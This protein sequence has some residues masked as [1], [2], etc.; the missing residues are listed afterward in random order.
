MPFEIERPQE[1]ATFGRELGVAAL[2][3]ASTVIAAGCAIEVAPYA[4]DACIAAKGTVGAI[5]YIS[6]GTWPGWAPP[7]YRPALHVP[8]AAAGNL[9]V[10]TPG[11]PAHCLPVFSPQ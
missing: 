8:H 4:G 1:G 6:T 10:W 9:P 7:E 5:I 2:V 11:R 3:C